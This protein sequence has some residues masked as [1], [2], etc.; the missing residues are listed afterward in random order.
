MCLTYGKQ[1]LGRCLDGTDHCFACG[2][3][4]HKI[5]DCPNLKERGEEVNQASLDPNAPKKNP[6]YGM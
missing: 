6:S 4:G 5:R 3:K 2:N 1:H